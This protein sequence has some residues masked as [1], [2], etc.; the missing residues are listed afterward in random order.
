MGRFTAA[1][2]C[3]NAA[4]AHAAR[5]LRLASGESAAEAFPQTPQVGPHEP[6]SVYV[7]KRLSRVRVQLDL[8]D[9]RITEQ[10]KAK[11]LDGQVLNWLCAAQERLAEQERILAGHP[12]PGS[13]HPKEPKPNHQEPGAWVVEAEPVPAVSKDGPPDSLPVEPPP[14]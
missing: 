2:A 3:E 1:N 7:I 4:K 12:L 13:R 14:G 11:T 10:A 8:V 5:R 9:R 6:P